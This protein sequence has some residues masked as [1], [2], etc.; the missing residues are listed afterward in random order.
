MPN[1]SAWM[2]RFVHLP[3][4]VRRHGHIKFASKPMKPQ[5]V[6]APKAEE[7]KK[8]DTK[9]EAHGDEGDDGEEK[10]KKEV[11]PLDVL[12][13]TTFDLYSFKTLFV[14]IP[15]K[16]GEGMKF[17]FENY[18]REGYCVYFVHYE[19]YADEGKVLHITLNLL[20]GFLQRI[21]NFRKHTFAM[22]A[23]LGDEPAL[24]IQG[25]W[26]FRGKGIP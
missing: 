9:K 4:V 2:E 26:L 12:P 19:M 20:N 7:K 24:Q 5:L 23:M 8:E 16:R 3:E 25:V 1:A 17:F 15:D 6:V 14:N 10:K 11:N 22:H 13:P 18:D 21:D